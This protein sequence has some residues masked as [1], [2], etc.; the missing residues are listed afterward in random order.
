MSV[1]RRPVIGIVGH[2]QLHARPFGDL[3]VHGAAARYADAV[4]ACGGRPV[5][6]PPGTG[7]G[8]LDLLDGVV[9]TGGDDLGADPAR[10]SDEVALVRAASAARVPVLGVC[11]GL[12]V[13]VVAFGGTLQGGL[14]HVHPATGHRVTTR[15]GS[16][17]RGLLGVSATTSALHRQAVADPGPAW[18]PTAWADD[19]VVEAIEPTDP[20]VTALGVQWHPELHWNDAPHD[21]TGPAVFAWLART[22]GS[23]STAR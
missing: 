1:V 4:A 15:P 21:A 6:V 22:A 7:P 10:D 23:R 9:L 19:G 5:I 17:V 13:L 3:P 20:A 11:R 2:L 8:L 18:R 12:Q 14:D 16:V